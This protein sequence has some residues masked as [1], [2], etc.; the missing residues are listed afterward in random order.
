MASAGSEPSVAN[1]ALDVIEL[2]HAADRIVH[3]LTAS[4]GTVAS[5]FITGAE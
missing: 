5:A 2:R 1:G 4:C 3:G